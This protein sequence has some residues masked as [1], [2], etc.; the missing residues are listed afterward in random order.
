MSF[1]LTK[2]ARRRIL[3][4]VGHPDQVT[5]A[6]QSSLIIIPMVMR[7]GEQAVLAVSQLLAAETAQ[8][9]GLES[10]PGERTMVPVLELDGQPVQLEDF[11][12]YNVKARIIAAKFLA[13]WLNGDTAE[14]MNWVRYGSSDSVLLITGLTSQLRGCLDAAPSDGEG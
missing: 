10:Q 13:A 9:L 4:A 2:A 7:H 8:R 3:D 5:A 11:T 12:D 6:T 14:Q 1:E